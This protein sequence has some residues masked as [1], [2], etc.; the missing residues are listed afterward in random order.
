[1]ELEM[2]RFL[3][4]YPALRSVPKVKE[5]VTNLTSI[6][7]EFYTKLCRYHIEY[8]PLE[9]QVTMQLYTVLSAVKHFTKAVASYM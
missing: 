5:A 3:P 8:I 2:L 1:M 6:F 9:K 7:E 4:R